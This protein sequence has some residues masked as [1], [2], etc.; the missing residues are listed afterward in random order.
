MKPTLFF[1]G[2]LFVSLCSRAQTNFFQ[3][4]PMGEDP[5][6]RYM[7]SY[8]P[9][10]TI[11]FEANPTVRYSFYSNFIDGLMSDAKRHTQAWYVFVKPQLRMYIE[12]SLP[13][14]T[15][16]YRVLIGTQHLFRLPNTMLKG[17]QVHFAGFSVES[18]HYSNGQ[19]GNAFSEQFDDDS[20][21]SDSIYN[22]ITPDTDLS[23]LLNRKSGNFSTNLTEI[24]FQY[25]RS[26]ITSTDNTPYETHS[27]NLGL[28]LYH[29]RFLGVADFGGYTENDIRI[30]GRIRYQAGYEYTRT[31]RKG[32]GRRIV[33]RESLELIQGAHK[34]VNPVRNEV[35]VTFYP[36]K[37]S[38]AFGFCGSYIYGH[39]NYNFRFVDAGNQL[40][41]GLTWTQFPPLQL[42]D[43]L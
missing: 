15:P 30:Y 36:F 3:P 20:P 40:T 38:K 39:D 5:N 19:S 32:E 31:F 13:V 12:N 14:K 43:R 25:R 23:K 42:S 26:K 24:Q 35:V 21:Q 1:C 6:I 22:T 17:R 9:E 4:Y 2:F 18:G 34:H 7:T 37:K 8:R 41:F 28:T 27:A 10:E 29:D 16:S 33:F 11:L